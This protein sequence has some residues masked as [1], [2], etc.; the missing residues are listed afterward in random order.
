LRFLREVLRADVPVAVLPQ[1]VPPEPAWLYWYDHHAFSRPAEEPRRCTARL[2]KSWPSCARGRRS[3]G[4]RPTPAAREQR[5]V[6]VLAG[7]VVGGPDPDQLLAGLQIDCAPTCWIK[8][9][10]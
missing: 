2:H 10:T 1:L 6:E 3:K 5:G 9:G 7:V 8:L 4:S